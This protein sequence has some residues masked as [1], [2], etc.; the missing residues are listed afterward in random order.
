MKKTKSYIGIL[1]FVEIIRNK[2]I[3][4]KYKLL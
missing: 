2:M 1:A 4:F 3:I